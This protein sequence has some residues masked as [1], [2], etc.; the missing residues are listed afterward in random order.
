[1]VEIDLLKLWWEVELVVDID[2]NK[3]GPKLKAPKE[4]KAAKKNEV[5][6]TPHRNPT[7]QIWQENELLICNVL[8]ETT[9]SIDFW[10]FASISLSFFNNS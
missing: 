3:M 10:F 5:R 4:V 7:A 2:E 8:C 1:M 6:Q 9:L